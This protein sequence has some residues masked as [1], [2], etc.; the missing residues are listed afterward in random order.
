M[1]PQPKDY[2]SISPS[3]KSLLLLKGYTGIPYAKETA[4][5]MPGSEVFDLDFGAKDFWFWMR[6]VHF[7]L[8]Y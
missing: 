2:S 8:R 6:V 5:L 1:N 3:A 7:E 4:A